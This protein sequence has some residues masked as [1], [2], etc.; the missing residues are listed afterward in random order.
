[1]ITIFLGVFRLI[2]VFDGRDVL[3]CLVEGVCKVVLA[4]KMEEF[5]HNNRVSLIALCPSNFVFQLSACK[6]SNLPKHF[7]LEDSIEGQTEKKTWKSLSCDY[8]FKPVI[9]CELVQN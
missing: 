4:E 1:M 7:R 3:F 6:A 8:G 9:T 5:N 2:N